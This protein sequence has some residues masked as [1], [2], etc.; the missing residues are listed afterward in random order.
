MS[1]QLV[2]AF[3]EFLEIELDLALVV[4]DRVH[5]PGV[6]D[7]PANHDEVVDNFFLFDM[8]QTGNDEISFDF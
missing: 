7:E 2:V 5:L 3:H 6:G 1:L 8:G 4:E